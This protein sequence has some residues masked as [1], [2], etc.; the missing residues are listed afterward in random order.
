MYNSSSH[1]LNCLQR[2]YSYWWISKLQIVCPVSALLVIDVR[3]DFISGSLSIKNCPAK[4]EGSEVVPVISRLLDTSR[5]DVVVYSCNW[6]PENHIS[7]IENVSLRDMHH[8]SKVSPQLFCNTLQH[9]SNECVKKKG[10]GFHK[11]NQMLVFFSPQD[12]NKWQNL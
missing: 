12:W 8:T 7:F 4:H 5:F 6:H 9:Y 1:Y 3:N 11:D 2:T 10:L